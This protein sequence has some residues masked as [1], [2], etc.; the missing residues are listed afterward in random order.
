MNA[1][2]LAALL[3]LAPQGEN[4]KVWQG[5]RG[6]GE[7]RTS[8]RNLPLR[9]SEQE[10]VAWQVDLTGHGQS[11]PVVWRDRVFVTSIDGE[12]QDR[13]LVRCLALADGKTLWEKEF[14]GSQGVKSS[15]YVSKAAPT[16]AVDGRHL[17]LFFESGDLLALTHAGEPVWQRSLVKEFGP[18]KSNHGLGSSPVLSPSG[19]LVFVTH[20]GGAYL[21]SVDPATGK[22]RW[23]RDHPFGAGWATP[24]VTEHAGKSLVLVSSSGRVDA[25]ETTTGEPVWHLTGL[26]GN[27]VPSPSSAGGVALI[28]SSEPGATMALRL[29]GK[30]DVTAS[31]VV[32]RQPEV[33][34]SF[35]SPLVHQGYVYFVNRAGVAHCLDLKD[36]N[37]QWET[38][39]TA[40]AWASPMAAGD[41]IYFFDTNGGT[42]VAKAGAKLEKLSE[43]KLPGS[44]KIYGIAAVDGALVIRSAGKLVRVGKP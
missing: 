14:K 43:N 18:I 37:I 44:G 40:S 39:L 8:A 29:D 31:H 42:L 3:V 38:R 10:N 19:L 5:F 2:T 25:F 41:R 20:E 27:T 9:W 36:G 15:D 16:P 6:N 24:L 11:S 13:L 7:S 26:K 35:G 23:K 32:W 12:M 21:L 28:G 30:G 17:Y 34:C 1:W 4:G 22:N 33:N